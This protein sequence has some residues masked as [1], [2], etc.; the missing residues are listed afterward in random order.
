ME[1]SFR[2]PE[3]QAVV[4]VPLHAFPICPRC[5][6]TRRGQPHVPVELPPD[7]WGEE[8]QF[9]ATDAPPEGA[10]QEGAPA[11]GAPAEAW[12][13]EGDEG[14]EE[15]DSPPVPA[16]LPVRRSGAFL[17]VVSAPILLAAAALLAYHTQGGPDW[18]S[19]GGW[20]LAAV[21]LVVLVV[22]GALYAA[23]RMAS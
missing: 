11:E 10:P 17:L 9:T 20:V 5:G 15:A 21:G 16:G 14:W 19:K 13:E 8:A 2:C 18:S 22:G 7:A 1:R 4:T 23:G 6:F 3:C 12:T